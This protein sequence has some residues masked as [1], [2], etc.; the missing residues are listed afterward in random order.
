MADNTNDK[1]KYVVFY[2]F[3]SSLDAL[4]KSEIER[5]EE[6]DRLDFNTLDSNQHVIKKSF[7][8]TDSNALFK[9]F[10]ENTEWTKKD[11]NQIDGHFLKADFYIGNELVNTVY[12]F[13]NYYHFGKGKDFL[14]D[15]ITES[16]KFKYIRYNFNRPYLCY[17]TRDGRFQFIQN[18]SENFESTFYSS[19]EQISDKI[20][21]LYQIFYA[22]DIINKISG[23]KKYQNMSAEEKEKEFQK[24]KRDYN[25]HDLDGDVP[26]VF[27]RHG[28]HGY[29]G[30][31]KEEE[32]K[33]LYRIFSSLG[34]DEDN[35]EKQ[36]EM[37]KDCIRNLEGVEDAF[38]SQKVIL[39][40]NFIVYE[41]EIKKLEIPSDKEID[42]L[43]ME[44]KNGNDD[45]L[46]KIVTSKLGIVMEIVKLYSNNGIPASDLLQEGNIALINTI[47]DIRKY[48]NRY[49]HSLAIDSLIYKNVTK[50]IVNYIVSKG[51]QIEFT[52]EIKLYYQTLEKFR[53]ILAFY[54]DYDGLELILN[55]K[56]FLELDTSQVIWLCSLI[57]MESEVFDS[58]IEYDLYDDMSVEDE[59]M[60]E[61]MKQDVSRLLDSLDERKRIMIDMYYGL[62]GYEKS[63]NEEIAKVVGGNSKTIGQSVRNAVKS[64]V[65]EANKLEL[66]E[67]LER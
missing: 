18:K 8:V 2:Y 20:S 16:E 12:N 19:Y 32:F 13:Y 22:D 35:I 52:P 60:K 29:I 47:K 17:Y 34:V 1:S 33:N 58:T 14:E 39:D 5:I 61:L 62:E 65:I 31:Q 44:Y 49:N 66:N 9:Y 36:E 40:D 30:K 27:K 7:K 3:D 55:I 21:D 50:T 24:I 4:L 57:S 43:I 6:S 15:K 25:M 64:L 63:S 42:T 56:E 41:D 46:N 51:I 48:G 10:S 54:K 28:L 67:Y 23:E 45:A 37:V 26:F 38:K 59:V 11:L 53:T